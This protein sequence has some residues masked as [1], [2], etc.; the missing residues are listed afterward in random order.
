MTTCFIS[1]NLCFRMSSAC[2]LENPPMHHLS[3]SFS[4]WFC[5]LF[6]VQHPSPAWKQ[7]INLL[8]NF[9]FFFFLLCWYQNLRGFFPPVFITWFLKHWC[10]AWWDYLPCYIWKTQKQSFINH[11]F[12]LA[13]N[14]SSNKAN[15]SHFHCCREGERALL[16]HS[17]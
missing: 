4:M 9:L 5:A 2:C 17:R 14:W 15:L 13:P 3:S 1:Q 6:I 12:R 10:E 7:I 11:F 16:N 8:L